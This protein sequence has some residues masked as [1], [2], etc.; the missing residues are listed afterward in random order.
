MDY[1]WFWWRDGSSSVCIHLLGELA[2]MAM[3]TSASFFFSCNSSMPSFFSVSSISFMTLI[4]SVLLPH[5]PY[6]PF[7]THSYLPFF[8]IFKKYFLPRSFISSYFHF[9]F[10]SPLMQTAWYVKVHGNCMVT[11][12]FS[13]NKIER[14]VWRIKHHNTPMFSPNLCD[15]FLLNVW[16]IT[17]ILNGLNGLHYTF[18]LNG[19]STRL[20]S[21]SPIHTDTVERWPDDRDSVLPKATLTCV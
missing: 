18:N 8:L 15:L 7:P 17:G 4:S 11:H 10:P 1:V 13:R 12:S 20:V 3:N 6:F 19:Q 14:G 5:F 9:L 2:N 16:L 21:R